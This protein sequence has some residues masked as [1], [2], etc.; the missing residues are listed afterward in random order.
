MLSEQLR[1]GVP[2]G[3]TARLDVPAPPAFMA[4]GSIDLEDP[5]I[6]TSWRPGLAQEPGG[7]LADAPSS[8]VARLE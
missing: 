1:A 5:R 2:P 7:L 3:T 8:T 6:S 4:T